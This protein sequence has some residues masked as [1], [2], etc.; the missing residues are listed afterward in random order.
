VLSSVLIP[1]G[2]I[3]NENA[4]VVLIESKKSVHST[5]S[6]IV[7]FSRSIPPKSNRGVRIAKE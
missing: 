5:K 4:M 7:E 3:F 6:G 1:T 2:K